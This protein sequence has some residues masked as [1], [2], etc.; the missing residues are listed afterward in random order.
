M[1]KL[2]RIAEKLRGAAGAGGLNPA[3]RYSRQRSSSGYNSEYVM[4]DQL[5][6]GLLEEYSGESLVNSTDF[7]KVNNDYGETLYLEELTGQTFTKPET[8][9]KDILTD[10]KLVYGI[11]EVREER[12]KKDGYE[13]I[14]DL[15]EHRKW[16]E[17]AKEV[18]QAFIGD[19]PVRGYNLLSRWKNLSHPSFIRLSGL[20][21]RNQF[22]IVD[23]ET[24]GLSNQP[25]F[26]LGLAR[27]VDRG[28]V[29]HQFLAE[30]PGKEIAT[31]IQFAKKLDELDVVLT[32]NGKNFDLP[33]IERRL[34]YY[35]Q[36][37]KF[38]QPHLDLYLFTRK[39][40]SDRT[41]NCQLGTIESSLLGIERKVDIPSALVPEFYNTYRRSGNPGPLIPILA[42]NRQ[43]LL[44]LADLYRV[45]TEEALNGS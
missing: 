35:G 38:S 2:D 12:L 21:D 15:E 34:A 45:V 5:K 30:N 3:R 32:Y 43:D 14:F 20:F 17:K 24:M 8:S 41:R 31:L 28:V 27:P 18:K 11:G 9:V 16:G 29:V 40:L 7:E 23:I 44:S 42:H 33:Y 1:G 39:F 37:R 22:A 4:A 25:I 26:L 13:T 6:K 19:S 36:R 10:L